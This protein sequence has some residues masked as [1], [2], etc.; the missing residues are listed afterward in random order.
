MIGSFHIWVRANDLG[1]GQP[2][3]ASWMRASEWWSTGQVKRASC[4]TSLDPLKEREK[5]PSL[6]N[7]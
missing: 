3:G 4:V 6:L 1:R 5:G 7:G 2:S